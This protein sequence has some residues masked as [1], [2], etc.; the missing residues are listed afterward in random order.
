MKTFFNKKKV[1][2]SLRKGWKLSDADGENHTSAH[3]KW[4]GDDFILHN[5]D[6]KLT[7]HGG[8]YYPSFHIKSEL[9]SLENE[10]HLFQT[11]PTHSSHR[12]YHESREEETTKSTKG[13]CLSTNAHK[14]T[15]L[16]LD[17]KCSEEKA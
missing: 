6:M 9:A 2:K 12:Q 15:E 16:Q 1:E 7:K 4:E 8:N 13:R 10:S 14:T 3:F 11:R 5:H 17:Q